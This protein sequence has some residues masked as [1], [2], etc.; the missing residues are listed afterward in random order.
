MLTRREF[1]QTTAVAPFASMLSQAAPAATPDSKKPNVLLIMVDDLFPRMSAYGYTEV[2]APNIERLAKKG[3]RFDR[4]YCQYPVCNPSRQSI[5]SGLRPE[6]TGI[7]KNDNVECIRKVRPQT[8]TLPQLFRQNGY[9][10]ASIGKIA[11]RGMDASGKLVDNADPLSWVDSTF[12][13][14]TANNMPGEGTSYAHLMKG[15]GWPHSNFLWCAAEGDDADQQDQWQAEATIKTIEA[16]KDGPFFIATGFHKPH[17]PYVA[18][19]SISIS[20]RSNRSPCR[21]SRPTAAPIRRS[22]SPC[23]IYSRSSP[24]KPG[25]SS[26]GATSPASRLSTRRSAWCSTTS[27]RQISGTIPLSSW[28][29]T[30][31]YH[32]WEH[33]WMGKSTSYEL[34]ARVPLLVW[35]PGQ[36]GMGKSA[37]GLVESLDIFP[38]LSALCGLTPPAE[39]QG[40]SFVP[41]L[42]DPSGPGKDAAYTTVI[43]EDANYLHHGGTRGVNEG[44]R[45]YS[46]R[47]DRYRFTQWSDGKTELYDHTTDPIEYHDL[48]PDPAHQPVVAQMTELLKRRDRQVAKAV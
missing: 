8:V 47:N 15:S 14:D 45:G 30:T 21:K 19:K 35:A 29:P 4:N 25:A 7:Y 41:L 44:R 2:K 40:T 11:H 26:S 22:A 24:P 23:T 34:S 37:N 31:G 38:S 32:L 9:Y 5:L 13:W 27:T 17:D 1:L 12:H 18:P 6:F 16:H 3:V 10:T 28:S 20:I 46:V 39:I 43:G 36:P 42:K 48:S 33:G